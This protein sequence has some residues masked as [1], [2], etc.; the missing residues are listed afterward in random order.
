LLVASSNQ[1]QEILNELSWRF[2]DVGY[3]ELTAIFRSF[4]NS[5]VR[6]LNKSTLFDSLTERFSACHIADVLRET[7]L[8]L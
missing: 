1:G 7:T 4:G 6:R 5:Y 2:E 3:G 8:W